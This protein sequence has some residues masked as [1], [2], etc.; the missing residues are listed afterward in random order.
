MHATNRTG[1]WVT[2]TVDSS[3]ALTGYQCSL[4]VDASN[5]VH[6]SYLD[7]T[8]KRIMYATNTTGSWVT[9]VIEA[10]NSN[11]SSIYQTSTSIAIDSSGTIHIIYGHM[12]S[13]ST[14]GS[15]RHASGSAGSFTS[16]DMT[17]SNDV[18]MSAGSSNPRFTV[19]IDSSNTLHVAYVAR[20]TLGLAY[21]SG[22]ANSYGSETDLSSVVTIPQYRLAVAVNSSNLPLILSHKSS[23]LIYADRT[24][25]SWSGGTAISTTTSGRFPTVDFTSSDVK[26]SVYEKVASG[27]RSA[28][29]AASS[30]SWT[31]ESDTVS[32][33][34]QGTGGVLDGADTMHICGYGYGDYFYTSKAIGSDFT[35][36]E[37]IKNDTDPSNGVI[38][39]CDIG[40]ENAEGRSNTIP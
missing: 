11:I 30:T 16:Y 36:M 40:V 38:Y 27:M 20:S 23:T 32:G 13:T 21:R 14:E 2:E 18:Y 29:A 34:L 28:T 19:A 7:Y 5:N 9:E 35:S 22:T 12:S 3:A 6:I 33:S 15:L 4:A 17:G 37:Y 24:G 25:G 10:T 8:N 26:F 31:Q 39:T 1:S